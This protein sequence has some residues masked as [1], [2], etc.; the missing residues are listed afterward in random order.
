MVKHNTLIKRFL[1]EC[2]GYYNL[3]EYSEYTENIVRQSI[4]QKAANLWKYSF[5]REGYIA[6]KLSIFAE[7]CYWKVDYVL[8]T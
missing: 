1:F 4:S 3:A 6:K 5:F 8:S 7:D 2:F